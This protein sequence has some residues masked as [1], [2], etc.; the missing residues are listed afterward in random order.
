MLAMEFARFLGLQFAGRVNPTDIVEAVC[1]TAARTRVELVCV[2][3]LS[4]LNLA[5]RAGAEV[6]DQLKY[7]AEWLPATL[8]CAADSFG[9]DRLVLGTDF[10]YETGA[11]FERAVSYITTSGLAPGGADC[12][13]SVNAEALFSWRDR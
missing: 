2:D 6:S 3:E 7:F 11:V 12:V 8:R 10:P 9:A 4:N 1:V 5:T 13:P